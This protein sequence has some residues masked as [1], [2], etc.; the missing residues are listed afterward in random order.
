MGIDI[1]DP[2]YK[3]ARS[4]QEKSADITA[5]IIVIGVLVLVFVLV[6]IV[7]AIVSPASASVLLCHGVKN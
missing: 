2:K 6:L 3:R 5:A 7:W 1:G 4:L